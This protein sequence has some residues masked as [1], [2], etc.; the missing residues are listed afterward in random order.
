MIREMHAT[1]LRS[2]PTTSVLQVKE[3]LFYLVIMVVFFVAHGVVIMAVTQP[4]RDFKFE[5]IREI[6]YYPYWQMFGELSLDILQGNV[7]LTSQRNGAREAAAV[8]SKCITI[9]T[10]T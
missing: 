2:A 7:T 9:I 5:V 10:V 4:T 6:F 8:N 1:T 3:L